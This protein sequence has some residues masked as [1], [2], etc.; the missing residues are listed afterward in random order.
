L[1]AGARAR[2][3][4]VAL[5]GVGAGDV[6][7]RLAGALSGW[8]AR[9]VDLLVLRDEE[10]AAVL[11]AAGVPPPFWI[12]ADPVWRD[13]PTTPPPRPT[14]D[15]RGRRRLLVGLS[16]LA[17]PSAGGSAGVER[18]ATALASLADDWEIALQP[19]QTAPTAD[20]GPL[21][22]RLLDVLPNAVVVDAPGD[23]DRAITD[24]AGADVVLGMRF[25]SVVAAGA[26]RTRFVAVAHEPKLA[27][28]ARR[29]GQPAVPAHAAP[30]VLAA[31]VERA[32]AG[33]PPSQHDIAAQRDAADVAFDLLTLMVEDG[34][35]PEPARLRGLE[36]SSGG[37]SW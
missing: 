35:L 10:S 17:A 13:V 1:V 23:F 24:A 2:G 37:G 28:A 7:G 8:I 16:H 33:E 3:V 31:A 36:L 12:A 18:L 34:A 9:H 29:L 30:A 15:A 21:A 32:A 20:D 27:A 25:H 11:S 4:P 14:G 6:R 22:R 26:A 5:I 19:W